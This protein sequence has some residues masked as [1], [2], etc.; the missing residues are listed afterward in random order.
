MQLIVIDPRRTETARRAALHLQPR[1]GEDP[2]MLAGIVHVII[3]ERLYDADVR[4]GERAGRSNASPRRCASSRRPR[5]SE[6]ADV[7]RRTIVR[8]AR[9]FAGAR[10]GCA[11]AGTGPSFATQGTLTEYLCLCLTTLCGRWAARRRGGPAPE[12]DA[13]RLHRPRPSPTPPIKGWGYGE[14]LRVRGLTQATCGMPTAA[15]ADEILLEGEG[16]VRALFC[17]GGNPMMAWPDQR[18]TRAAMEKLELLVTF[19]PEMSATSRWRTT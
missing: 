13:A 4:R 9:I 3:E 14:K 7:P 11:S 19:D 18:R 5:S 10:R 17:L 2:A 8:A 1:P 15:L 16:Q 12:R 6:R